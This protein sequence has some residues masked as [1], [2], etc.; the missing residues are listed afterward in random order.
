[1]ADTQEPTLALFIDFDNV[2]LGAR[3]SGVQF[4]IHP[5]LQRLVSLSLILAHLLSSAR[6]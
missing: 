5:L 3:D 6:A 1:M 2:A 4:D